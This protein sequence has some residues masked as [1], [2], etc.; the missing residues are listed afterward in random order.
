MPK[1]SFKTSGEL[2]DR[3]DDYF[4]YIKGEYH[5]EN[6]ANKEKS[7][8]ETKQTACI[9]EPEPATFTGLAIFLGFNS[10]QAFEKYEQKG[11]FASILKL[12]RLRIEATYEKRLHQPHACWSNV[13]LKK[14]WLERKAR[15]KKR[16]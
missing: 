5:L 15:T 1:H 13:C 9:R 11:R 10:K 6:V 3:I 8:I 14:Q 16:S 7:K 4:N 12:G 2:K